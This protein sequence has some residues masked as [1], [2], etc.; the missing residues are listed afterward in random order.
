MYTHTVYQKV[1]HNH[2]CIR[3][4][5]AE[6]VG[7]SLMDACVCVLFHTRLLSLLFVQCLAKNG[8]RPQMDPRAWKPAALWW[9]TENYRHY[10]TSR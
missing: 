3:I 7:G 5:R 4:L 2:K 10:L 6:G 1:P 9:I 8:W